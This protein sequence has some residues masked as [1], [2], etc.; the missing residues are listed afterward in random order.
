M[1][2]IIA[3]SR[4]VSMFYEADCKFKV[5]DVED[6]MWDQA[7]NRPGYWSIII[8]LRTGRKTLPGCSFLTG[9]DEEVIKRRV[10]FTQKEYALLD[11]VVTNQMYSESK[12]KVYRAVV[13]QRSLQLW[14]DGTDDDVAMRTVGAWAV[15]YYKCQANKFDE[16]FQ[17]CRSF[18]NGCLD[19]Y[20]RP[21][22]VR[23][24]SRL[25]RT[26][27][28]VT[29]KTN[30]TPSS[31]ADGNAQ[32]KN[33]ERSKS[34]LFQ[35]KVSPKNKLGYQKE[36]VSYVNEHEGGGRDDYDSEV[37]AAVDGR[38]IRKD[39]GVGVV[40]QTIDDTGRKQICGVLSQ[41]LS[42]E[43]NVYAQELNNAITAI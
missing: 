20:F 12:S 8:P 28:L 11:K 16:K 36:G 21:F 41:P 27:Q 7:A 31:D 24:R 34:G 43:P 5:S 13:Y 15:A 19:G 9:S 4:D 25:I 40:G 33:V 18:G 30:I 26:G 35:Q 22:S 39:C 42:V 2:G 23:Y 38:I 32:D 1:T 14:D 10:N 17:C 29:S 6:W 37:R 3:P